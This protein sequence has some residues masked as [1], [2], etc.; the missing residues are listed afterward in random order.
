[1]IGWVIVALYV[2]PLNNQYR[3]LNMDDT[4]KVGDLLVSSL[5]NL[6]VVIPDS[7]VIALTVSF[8]AN[9]ANIMSGRHCLA[10]LE[11]DD[12]TLESALTKLGCT[13]LFN[14]GEFFIA[15]IL[16]KPIGVE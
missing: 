11:K 16:N 12:T 5:H 15:R 10:T 9:V 14:L 13:K 8:G 1:M 4:F 2:V 3:G 6:Y 7:K